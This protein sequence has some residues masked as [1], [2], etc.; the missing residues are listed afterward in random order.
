MTRVL[1]YRAGFAGDILMSSSCLRGIKQKHPDC[2]LT[3]GLWRQYAEIVA[4]SPHVTT[5]V[6]PGHYLVT[7]YKPNVVDFRHES[8]MADHPAV[9]WGE[10]HAM[11]AAEKGLLDLDE[12]ESF[13]PE[14]F[15]GPDDAAKKKAEKLCVVNCWSQNGL[16]WRLWSLEKWGELIPELQ[17]MGYKV[18]HVGGSG[19]PKIPCN[20]DLRG[21]TRLAQVAGVVAIA[22]L[23]VA[24]DSFVAHVAHSSIFVRDVE[25]DTIEK[26][27]GS[28][29]TVLLAGPIAPDCVVPKDAKCVSVSDYPNC[30]GPCG[31]SH[32]GTPAGRICKHRNSCMKELAVDAVLAGVERCEGMGE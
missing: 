12:M 4:L 15:I 27:R 2:E 20:T 32:P 10:L 30:G 9:Y 13:K 22:D 24:I 16:G 11:Q 26:I 3:Y 7:D 14:F 25:K 8:L 1:C 21:K 28:V 31:I 23:V 5:V 29:P 6:V 19:D 17:A 18:V